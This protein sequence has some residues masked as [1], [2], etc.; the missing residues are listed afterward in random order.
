MSDIVTLRGLTTV[1]FWAADLEGAKKWYAELLGIDPYFER[2]GYA[3]FR[4]G[5]YQQELGLIDSR[6]A[7]DG[8]VASPAGAVVYWHVDDMTSTFKKLLSMGAKE[9]EAPTERGEGFITA[10][11]IDPFGNILGIMYNQ[12]YLDVLS[13][14]RKA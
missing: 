10:S 5:D 1:S 14:T 7:P 11:V 6:Y 4:L 2:P 13:L 8:S 3:E 9:Y 12:H